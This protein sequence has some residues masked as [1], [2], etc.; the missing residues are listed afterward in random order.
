MGASHTWTIEIP[1]RRV[2]SVQHAT[3]SSR[4]TLRLDGE[5]IY[6]SSSSHALWDLGFNHEFEL[7]GM[8]AR[9]L[10]DFSGPSPLYHLW[11]NG[12]IQHAER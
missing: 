12:Q 10:I 2:V 5:M 1:E 4:V 9:L 8:P 11:V 3:H 6:Q 7:D